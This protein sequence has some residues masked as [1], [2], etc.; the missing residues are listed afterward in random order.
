MSRALPRPVPLPASALPA[1]AWRGRQ[2]VRFGDCD[3]AG[4]VFFPAW[5]AMGH[6]AL[7]DW[8][9]EALGIGFHALH[10]A[11]RIAT[12]YAHAEADYFRPGLM[13]EVV[14]LTPLAGRIGGASYALTVHIHR[15]EEELARLHLLVATTDLD[16]R[17]PVAVPE[18]LRA[19]LL[20]Y[21]QRC[22]GPAG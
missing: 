8:F 7:E 22:G 1:A 3:P 21:R 11:R 10:A 12:G 19:A 4:I 13:G 20:A 5:F 15:G 2:R 18:D 9:D 14:H 6:A 17:R 16:T